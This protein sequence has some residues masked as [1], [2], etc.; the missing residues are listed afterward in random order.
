[1]NMP[2]QGTAADL[3]KIAMV[4]LDREL[5]RQGL[6]ARLILQVHDELIVEAP[7]AEA[8]RVKEL[9]R[10]IM[11]N[12]VELKVPLLVDI[13]QGDSWYNCKIA[14]GESEPAPPED[15]LA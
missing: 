3:I 12:V 14:E 15:A 9:M 6:A 4:R 10:R 5:R 13:D 8:E 7:L 1:M 2:L 11:E